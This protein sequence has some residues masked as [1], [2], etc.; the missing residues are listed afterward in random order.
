MRQD[1]LS[2]L[3]YLDL[4]KFGFISIFLIL[5]SAIPLSL[6]VI[7]IHLMF[8]NFFLVPVGDKM[9]AVIGALEFFLEVDVANI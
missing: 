6:L 3:F 7:Q 4:L 1:V 5:S 8:F 2:G 9:S